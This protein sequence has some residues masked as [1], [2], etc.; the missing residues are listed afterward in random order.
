METTEI[1]PTGDG[2]HF[3]IYTESPQ[4]EGALRRLDYCVPLGTYYNCRGKL[5]QDFIVKN[6]LRGKIERLLKKTGNPSKPRR[7]R[8]R[9]N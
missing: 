9:H 3:I 5:G 6:G 2:R 1:R 7:G 4:V 8:N